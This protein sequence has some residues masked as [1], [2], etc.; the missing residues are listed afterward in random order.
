MVSDA[1]KKKKVKLSDSM[2]HLQVHAVPPARMLMVANA[3]MAACEH[4]VHVSSGSK[5]GSDEGKAWIDSRR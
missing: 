5:G 4:C 2:P 3:I 1:A